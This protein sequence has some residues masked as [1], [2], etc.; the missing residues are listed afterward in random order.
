MI[1]WICHRKWGARGSTLAFVCCAFIFY[2]LSVLRIPQDEG[3]NMLRIIEAASRELLVGTNPHHAFPAIAGDAP[4]GYLPMLWLPYVILVWLGLDLRIFNLVALV[5]L[6]LLFER[7]F[8]PARAAGST[9]S[10][11]LPDCPVF[12]H[13][14]NGRAWAC[15][16][17][18]AFGLWWCNAADQRTAYRRV[19]C[20]RPCPRCTPTR[21]ISR[22]PLGSVRITRIWNQR[23]DQVCG[24]CCG[25]IPMRSLTICRLDRTGLRAECVFQ[26]F[27]HHYFGR[28]GPLLLAHPA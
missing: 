27:R 12:H 18:L 7:G 17:V 26:A 4:F 16:V 22:R 21:P 3:A 20:F 28:A 15:V 5:L 14:C 19:H 13:C 1:A 25:C 11:V 6:V 10:G 8:P 24:S 2:T 9:L 23:R